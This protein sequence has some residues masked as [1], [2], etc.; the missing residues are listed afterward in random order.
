MTDH[1]AQ[2]VEA[3]ADAINAP[4]IH[5]DGIY[6]DRKMDAELAIRAALPSLRR[7]IAEEVRAKNAAHIKEM[8]GYHNRA[9]AI[10]W[11]TAADFVEGK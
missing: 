10:G 6:H 1:F 3:G 2:A 7:M 11:E 4:R 8:G 5:V 9:V